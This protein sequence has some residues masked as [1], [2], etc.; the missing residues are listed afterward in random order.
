MG[1][2]PSGGHT[3]DRSVLS[4]ITREIYRRL[5]QKFEAWCCDNGKLAAPTTV[6]TIIDFLVWSSE[7]WGL[8][9]MRIAVCAIS[10]RN[11]S[12]GTQIDTAM[13]RSCILGLSRRQNKT[14]RRATALEL[15]LLRQ[16]IALLPTSLM[17]LRSKAL[18][19]VGFA[20]ALRGNEL[21]GLDVGTRSSDCTGFLSI[22]RRYMRIE[23]LSPKVIQPNLDAIK[24]IP[25]G[26]VP[27]AVLATEE[28][29]EA[30]NIRDG[31][32]FRRIRPFKKV[33]D[34][35]ISG[36]MVKRV[37]K[38]CVSKLY[39]SKGLPEE[40][41]KRLVGTISAYSLRAG[42][43]TSAYKQGLNSDAIVRHLGWR[44]ASMA[45]RYYRPGSGGD[46]DII[47]QLHSQWRGRQDNYSA[48]LCDPLMLQSR[49]S[50][51]RACR[52][53]AV[54]VKKSASGTRPLTEALD[55]LETRGISLAPST[56][57]SYRLKVSRFES[58][59]EERS[60]LSLPTDNK[61]FTE[62]LVE[63]A[64][65]RMTST[66]QSIVSAVTLANRAAGVS[67]DSSAPREVVKSIGKSH[68]LRQRVAEPIGLLM[69]RKLVAECPNTTLGKRDK[70]MLVIGFFGCLRAAEIIGLDI[71]RGGNDGIGV[72]MIERDGLLI[73][74]TAKAT[75][76]TPIR[77]IVRFL[78][79]G[80]DPCPVSAVNALMEVDGMSSGALFRRVDRQGRISGRRLR[81]SE[82][83]E[84]VRRCVVD[85]E[86]TA[87]TSAIIAK[88]NSS[89]YSTQSLRSGFICSALEAG[90]DE[91][92]IASHVG[93]TTVQQIVRCQRRFPIVYNN[94]V[95]S[96][97]T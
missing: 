89:Q 57:S 20:G 30:A 47:N 17:G 45:V 84:I 78:P 92:R 1:S 7:R 86:L 74:V 50:K 33:I 87:G 8:A 88:S 65:W 80:V 62:Y 59:C 76:R 3:E 35:R 79:R 75:I 14:S 26:G 44:S 73:N 15:D 18:L 4:P 39:R 28:W 83:S 31:P 96:V 81:T 52:G 97:L 6:D 64:S 29:L 41:V 51:G 36:S 71:N 37:I 5:Y 25:R 27:C 85:S 61:V 32:V 48:K 53:S 46:R 60:C 70:A 42:F 58:W 24:Y 38:Q 10:A 19:L 21:S 13:L 94:P 49:A 67:F 55:N 95:R 93:F 82:P 68:G 56:M 22:E 69:L 72:V 9:T 66:I 12:I 63:E 11:A 77:T 34:L 40:E 16:S 23:L 54:N 90:L 91:V 2:V 43:V